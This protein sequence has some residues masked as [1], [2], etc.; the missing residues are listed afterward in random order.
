MGVKKYIIPKY[1]FN[2]YFTFKIL[3]LSLKGNYKKICYNMELLK[4]KKCLI[5]GVL[6]D[7]SIAWGIAQEVANQGAELCLTYLGEAGQ[8]RVVPLAEKLNTNFTLPCDVSNEEDIDRVFT[9][10]KK[11]WGKLDYL[12]HA[13]AF[14][15]KNELKGGISD[16]SAIN[17][18]TTM[19]ISCYSLIAL[20]KRAKPLMEKA[21]EG[22]IITLTYYGS[23]K[24]IPHYNVM[25]IAK[26]AL[27]ATVRYLAAEFG[28]YNIRVNAI[29][30]GPVKTMAASGIG[31]FNYMLKYNE[32]NCPLKKNVT[33]EENGRTAVYLLS[34]MSSSMTGEILHLDGGYHIVGM[35]DPETDNIEIPKGTT[36]VI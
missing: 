23:E 8:K 22:S 9:E 27:E 3:I 25:G 34:N 15:D 16:T 2:K 7:K 12:I 6:N 13:V 20:A 33:I 4:G 29:S 5:F 18:A 35:K 10:I 24:Y 19:N 21:G 31:D 30:S 11:K 17:F 14:S 28:K 26:A 1:N 32:Y 36:N